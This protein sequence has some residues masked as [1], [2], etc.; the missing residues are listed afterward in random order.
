[1]VRPQTGRAHGGQAILKSTA[2]N[3]GDGRTWKD[4][5]LQPPLCTDDSKERKGAEGP[6]SEPRQANDAHLQGTLPGHTSLS[7]SGAPGPTSH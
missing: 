7:D 4:K 1:M 5:G 3:T 2:S 6:A